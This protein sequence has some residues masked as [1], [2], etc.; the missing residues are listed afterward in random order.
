MQ[1]RVRPGSRP[2]PCRTI[3]PVDCLAI[4]R[5]LADEALLPALQD[6]SHIWGYRSHNT[7][8]G[9]TNLWWVALITLGEGWH[10]N[11]HAFPRSAKHGLRWWEVDVTYWL[12]RLMGLVGLARQIRVPRKMGHS[13]RVETEGVAAQACRS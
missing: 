5:N 7:P 13:G 4:L 2:L 9:S 8:D 1:R 12:I 10:N 3:R 6:A 11:H